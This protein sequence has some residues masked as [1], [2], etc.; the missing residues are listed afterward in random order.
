MDEATGS[1]TRRPTGFFGPLLVLSAL[2]VALLA[3]AGLD[4]LRVGARP[5]SVA[6]LAASPVDTTVL[7]IQATRVVTGARGDT[8]TSLE[9]WLDKTTGEGKIIETAADGTVKRIESFSDGTYTL[10]LGDARHVVIRSGLRPNGPYTGQV[11]AELLRY[12]VSLERGVGQ[13][14]GAGQIGGRATKRIR[15]EINGVPV[16]AD[17]DPDTG[18]TLREEVSQPGGAREIRDTTYSAVQSV[19]RADLGAHSF[20]PELPAG[21]S[22]EEY[23]DDQGGVPASAAGVSYAVYAAPLSAGLPAASFRRASGGPAVPTSDTYYLIYQTPEG[24]VQV[25]SSLPPDPAA[26][27]AKGPLPTNATRPV[28]IGGTTW[29]VATSG[30]G[31][32][33]RATLDDA[34]VTIF[35]PNQAT[36]ERIAQGLRRLKPKG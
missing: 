32:Q 11:R 20:Q 10:Y 36:F 5:G 28:A 27:Q 1:R 22:R 8:L 33:A 16:V 7:H 6:A 9:A 23:A 21:V 29:E 18:L 4:R 25:L 12:Q 26:K 24:E 35:A 14:V 30:T 31:I 2:L 17:V 34:Y 3:I 13:L 19:A 15:L